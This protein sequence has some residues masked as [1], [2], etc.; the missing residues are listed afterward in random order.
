[1]TAPPVALADVVTTLHALPGLIRERRLDRDLS[2]RAAAIEAGVHFATFSRAERGDFGRDRGI[3]LGC[4]VKL[5]RWLD[6]PASPPEEQ[7]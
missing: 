4:A 1:V 2:V 3:S 7:P 6:R 5:L